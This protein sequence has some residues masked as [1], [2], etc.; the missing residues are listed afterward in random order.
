MVG[1]VMGGVVFVVAFALR[2]MMYMSLSFD[3]RVIDGLTAARF[4]VDIK[5]RL[6]TWTPEGE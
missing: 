5:R 2:Q 3:H 6:E 4:L 1:V